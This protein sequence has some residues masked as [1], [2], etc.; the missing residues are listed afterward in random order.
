MKKQ[1]EV[2][3]GEGAKYPM[4][5]SKHHIW[6]GEEGTIYVLVDGQW[7]ATEVNLGQWQHVELPELDATNSKSNSATL[8]AR[9][10]AHS[11]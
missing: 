7:M 11:A 1:T 9:A 6:L 4:V 10:A 3:S 2:K 5:V 8:R